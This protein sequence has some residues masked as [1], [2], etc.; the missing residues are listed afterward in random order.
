MDALDKSKNFVVVI[1]DLDYLNSH[2]VDLEMKTFNKEL[3]EGRKPDGNF[4]IVVT[5]DLFEKIISTN[6][7][8]LPIQY[9][10]YE[11]MMTT[12]YR[13]RL[14]PYLKKNN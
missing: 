11:I 9:R 8:C 3:D 4:I 1:S 7:K 6:K 13:E 2:W 10:G 5:P 12:N 14:I